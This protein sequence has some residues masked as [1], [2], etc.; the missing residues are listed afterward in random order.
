MDWWVWI[1]VIAVVVG[2]LALTIM[3]VQARR[4]SGGV[5]AV[6]RRGRGRTG[7]LK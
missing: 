1:V 7:G 5:I 6:K 2:V 4:R 3:G